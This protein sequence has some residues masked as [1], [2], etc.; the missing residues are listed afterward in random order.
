MDSIKKINTFLQQGL[1]ATLKKVVNT[2]DTVRAVKIA[3]KV[4]G[5]YSVW[6]HKAYNHRN[7][8]LV[9]LGKTTLPINLSE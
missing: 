5:A 8:A 7:N 3:N 4:T 6:M 9:K 1:D 2:T